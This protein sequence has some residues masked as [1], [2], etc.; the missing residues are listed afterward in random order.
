MLVH[1]VGAVE[2]TLMR[3]LVCLALVA[4]GAAG[5]TAQTRPEPSLDL[6]VGYQ[7]MHIPGQTYPLGISLEMSGALTSA[8]RIV[9]EAGVSIARR[10]ISSYGAGTLTLYDY[11]GGP[12]VTARAGRALVY[13]QLLGGGVRT[14]ADLSTAS[15]APFI[16]GD[17]AFMLQPGAGVIVPLTR[18]IAAIG[19]VNYERVFFKEYGGDNETRVFVGVR[20]AIR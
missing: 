8:V 11:G 13:G 4:A 7:V 20:T 19:E 17:S 5:A 12:R 9:A 14:H 3:A 18:K 16:E 1:Y 2:P 6:S 15:G 10:T